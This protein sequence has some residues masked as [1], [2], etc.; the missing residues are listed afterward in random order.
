MSINAVSGTAPVYSPCARSWAF[1]V[2]FMGSIDVTWNGITLGRTWFDTAG[3]GSET[4]NGGAEVWAGRLHL[5][6]C[7]DT[8]IRPDIRTV[9]LAA[10]AVAE[11]V[12]WCW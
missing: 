10:F 6:A 5:V 2:P 8:T 1:D 4:M 12:R 11:V 7:R 9:A 3:I